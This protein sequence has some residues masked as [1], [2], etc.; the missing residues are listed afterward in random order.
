MQNTRKGADILQIPFVHGA[1][2]H[3]NFTNTITGACS[4]LLT[5]MWTPW[6]RKLKSMINK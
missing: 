1:S 4:L 5:N 2:Y 6:M 3:D